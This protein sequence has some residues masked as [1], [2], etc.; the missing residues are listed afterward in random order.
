MAFLPGS[1]IDRQDGPAAKMD[2]CLQWFELSVVIEKFPAEGVA[3]G[4]EC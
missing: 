4:F 1:V 2:E 3:R